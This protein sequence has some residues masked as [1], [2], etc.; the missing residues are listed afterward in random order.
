VTTPPTLPP[1]I[2]ADSIERR[3]GGRA[4]LRSAYVDAVAGSIT[5]LVGVS[6]SGKTTLL[7]ILTGRLRA[8]GGQVRWAGARLARP[9]HAVL[10][11]LGLVYAPDHPWLGTRVAVRH[12]LAFAARMWDGDAAVA[13]R[14]AGVADLLDRR[15]P[16]LSTGERRLCELAL[17]GVARPRALV[18]DEPFRGLEP[19]HRDAVA[20]FLVAQ[21]RAGVAV[22]FADHDAAQVRQT[23]DRVFSIEAGQTRPVPG[24][25][26]RPV[27]E[28]YHAWGGGAPYI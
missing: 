19:L 3:F 27:G 1:V 15:T 2:A 12:Q 13:V 7:E 11:R 23:A 26:D 21:A 14:A 6:G 22:L 10:A 18:L 4:V 8:H 28:W 16:A 25:R 17:A 20:R 24:F 9:S 5:A